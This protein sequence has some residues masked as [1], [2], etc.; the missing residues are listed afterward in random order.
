LLFYKKQCKHYL[1]NLKA[2][3]YFIRPT[4]EKKTSH[5]FKG[6]FI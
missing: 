3:Q 2:V 4:L 1:P 5:S 6:V